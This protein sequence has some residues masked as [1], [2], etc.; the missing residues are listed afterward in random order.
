MDIGYNLNHLNSASLSCSHFFPRLYDF[1]IFRSNK[2]NTAGTG[3]YF[4]YL[5]L[6]FLSSLKL[7]FECCKLQSIASPT[8]PKI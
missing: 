7:V 1:I 6:F 8:Y 2:F 5:F 4:I 3:S